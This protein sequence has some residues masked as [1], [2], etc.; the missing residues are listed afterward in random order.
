MRR[1]QLALTS[2]LLLLAACEGTT[3][4]D[5]LVMSNFAFSPA[6][7]RVP[8]DGSHTLTVVN[9]SDQFH[10]LTVD[11]L[12]DGSA[13]V[14]LGLFERASAPYDLPALP[15]GVYELYCSVQGHREAGMEGTF[16]VR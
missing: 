5:T 7:V 4:T 13:P 2:L 6:E 12:P 16:V 8:A 10:D 3:T 9:D 11:G 15:P 14:H 1:L